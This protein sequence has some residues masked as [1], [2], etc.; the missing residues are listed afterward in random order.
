VRNSEAFVIGKITNVNDPQ[1][2]GRVQV[3]YPHL[4]DTLTEWSSVSSIMAGAGRGCFFMPEV[5]DEVLVA[6]QHGDW[7]HPFIIGFVWNPVQ[8]P[9]AQDP[10][11]RMICSTNQ[12]KLIF[13]DS[14]PT[15]GCQ[16]GIVIQDAHGNQITMTA[17][18]MDIYSP[19]TIR[20]QGSAVNL[21]GRPVRGTGGP[22]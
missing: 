3:R 11:Q 8:A 5:D 16:G 21:Q 7:N 14:T 2:Q 22:I 15:D 4:Q 17:W 13:L 10:R 1:N 6:P 12:H 18:G 19:G 9:P 20:I